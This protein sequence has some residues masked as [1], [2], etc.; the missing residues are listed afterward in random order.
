[1]PQV[2]RS[3][4]TAFVTSSLPSEKAG[5]SPNKPPASKLQ[6]PIVSD[7]SSSYSFLQGTT[8]IFQVFHASVTLYK[9]K[10]D[11]IEC[12]GFTAF[13]LT[14]APYSVMSIVDLTGT[15]VTPTY[16]TA[17]LVE[18]DILDEARRRGGY[19][20]GAVRRL[21]QPEPAPRTFDALIKVDS[22]ERMIISMVDSNPGASDAL[23]TDQELL[24]VPS[25][26]DG[27]DE[28]L[29]VESRNRDGLVIGVPGNSN[30]L[31]VKPSSTHFA[32]L[33]QTMACFARFIS[34]FFIAFLPVAINAY[35]SHFADGE[36]AVFGRR[37]LWLVC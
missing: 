10:G 18:S 13:A 22:P 26:L 27:S 6:L 31:G 21:A 32:K 3:W 25:S 33:S 34:G 17:F 7:I 8:A 35:F 16:S 37:Q 23:E 11:Q 2:S 4:R 19:F 9:A 28:V 24:A 15:I 5:L 20:R 12:Y 30:S 36:S 14:V 1:M 29:L